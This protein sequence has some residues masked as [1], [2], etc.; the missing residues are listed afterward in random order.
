ME[1]LFDCTINNRMVFWQKSEAK[2]H[3]SLIAFDVLYREFHDKEQLD[4]QSRHKNYYLTFHEELKNYNT[5]TDHASYYTN[6]NGY[7]TMVN[8]LIFL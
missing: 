6:P 7:I 1:D 2:D 5:T 3:V 4:I 8:I